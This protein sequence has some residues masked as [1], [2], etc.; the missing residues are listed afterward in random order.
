M[1]H[2]EGGSGPS[3]ADR[4]FVVL[5]ACAASDRPLSLAEL[6]RRTGLP[7]TTLHRVCW[8]LVKLGLLEYRERGFDIGTKLFAL[9]SMNARLRQLRTIGMPFLQALATDSRQI[10]NLAVQS[11]AQALIV[12]EIFGARA[13]GVTPMGGAR[14]P[15]HATAI[16]KALSCG[17]C[18][19]ELAARFQA[20]ALAPFTR[21]TIVRTN[22]LVE[23]LRGV[24]ATGLAFSHEEW[25]MGTSA[26]AAPVIV[27]GTVVAAVAVIGRTDKTAMRWVADPVRRTAQAFSAALG[28]Q[29]T[30]IGLA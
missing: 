29:W 3:V 4:V 19:D 25:R 1:R 23:H 30:P 27:D 22:L 24:R 2:Q 9:G 20:P 17:M 16:G 5:E 7:K 15:L 26:V 6:T 12:E 14:M 11:D 18:E 8:K 13:P 10:V 28:E 21:Y